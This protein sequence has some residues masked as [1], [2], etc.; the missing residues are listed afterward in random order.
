MSKENGIKANVE[1]DNLVISVPIETVIYAY[2]NNQYNFDLKGQLSLVKDKNDFIKVFAKYI[3]EYGENDESGLS[4]LERLFD[5][6]FGEMYC[7]ALDCISYKDD[8]E[9]P[10]EITEDKN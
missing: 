8:E 4:A 6:I 2:E 5:E 7:D 9:A 3:E 10:N 1:K